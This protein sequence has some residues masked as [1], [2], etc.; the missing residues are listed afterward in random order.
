VNRVLITGAAGSIGAVLSSG[1]AERGYAV[2]GLDRRPWDAAAADMVVGDCADLP[3]V[4]GALADVDAVVHLAG[5]PSETDLPTALS[6]HVLTTGTVLE[7]MRQHGVGRLVYAS[8]NH[9]VG[10]HG[11]VASLGVEAR[12]RPDTFYGVGKVAAEALISLYADRYGLAAVC[13]RIGSFLPRPVSRRHLETWLSPGDA[14]RL[15]DACLTAPDVRFEVLYGISGNT[16][17]W[18]DLGPARALGYEPADD[19]E[20]YAAEILATPASAQDELDG[21]RVG[22]EFTRAEYERPAFGSGS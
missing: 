19:A 17:A 3:T 16:R 9:A 6:S 18:W 14:V 2:R 15:V 13:L 22:G 8:S 1:L 20:Q 7:A 5:I 4:T 10:W 11:R 21:L 12:P